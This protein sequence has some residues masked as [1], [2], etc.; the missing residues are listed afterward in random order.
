M[1][2]KQNFYGIISTKR[3]YKKIFKIN[4]IWFARKI[5][6]WEIIYDAIIKKKLKNFYC[7]ILIINFA[8]SVFKSLFRGSKKKKKTLID[9][10]YRLSI[11]IL[12]VPVA[13]FHRTWGWGTPS[14]WQSILAG[15][16]ATVAMSFGSSNQRGGTKNITYIQN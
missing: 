8:E 7:E 9:V 3:Y 14:A 2:L 4:I 16:P 13:I 1:F 10:S 11:R 6:K 15:R 12:L 5:F